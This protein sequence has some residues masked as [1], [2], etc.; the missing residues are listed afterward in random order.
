M[1]IDGATACVNVWS[2]VID[3][4]AHNDARVALKHLKDVCS[5]SAVLKGNC[6]LLSTEV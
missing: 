1:H 6:M 3:E 5:S 4:S 2:C